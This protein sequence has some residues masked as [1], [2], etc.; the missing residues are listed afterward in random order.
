MTSAADELEFYAVVDSKFR[1]ELK[2]QNEQ[3]IFTTSS[4]NSQTQLRQ[5]DWSSGSQVVD[6]TQIDSVRCAGLDKLEIGFCLF[7]NQSQ[8][9]KKEPQVY[10]AKKN[11]L[12]QLSKPHP[13]LSTW[14]IHT[15]LLKRLK[16]IQV[17]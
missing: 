12:I 5:T 4:N 13:T 10:Y 9:N 6:A 11:Y 2:R 16:T 17:N 8:T 1:K 15:K 14:Q 3:F 7:C